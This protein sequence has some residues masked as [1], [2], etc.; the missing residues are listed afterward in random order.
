MQINTAQ[1]IDFNEFL[2]LPK[3]Q[4]FHIFEERENEVIH[5]RSYASALKDENVL[6]N[7]QL[8]TLRHKLFGRSSEKPANKG[9]KGGSSRGSS[10]SEK[11]KKK[12]QLPSERYPDAP[13][14]ETH[15]T[16]PELPICKCCGSTM[17]DSGMTEDSEFLTTIPARHF[18]V[19]QKRH[20][21]RCSCHGDI[22]TAPGPDRITPGGSYSDDMIIDVALN[23]YCNLVPI[24]RYT[25]IAGREG[26]KDLPSHS[27]IEATHQLANF[28]EPAYQKVRE[29]VT[30]ALVLHADET[31]HKMLEGD[32]TP[33]WF[34]WAFSTPFSSYFD[35]RDTRSGDVASELLKD[36]RCEYLSSDVFSG[37]GKAVR[38]TNKYRVEK[39]HPEIKHVFCNAHV[40]RKFKESAKEITE[41]IQ[42]FL[43]KY[44]A[45]YKLEKDSREAG[46]LLKRR[47]E[48]MAH[49]LE[50]K[51]YAES[52]LTSNSSKSAI[53]SACNYFLNNYDGFTRF[54]DD[55][56]LPIDNNHQ[57]RQLRN[58]VIGRKTWFGTHSRRGAQTA[59]ILFS[60][61]ESCKLNEVNPRHYFLALVE[62]IHSKKEP[63][64]PKSYRE[65]LSN[66]G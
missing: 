29:E 48:M 8:V 3:E 6:I 13:L 43:D 41:E 34:L 66:T 38:E 18:V 35:I 32:K 4:Q 23:K 16:F 50:M 26:F 62:G 37:Y 47:Q 12:I 9:A 24:D 20:K 46:G 14:I 19:R 39:E 36:S 28:V 53:V 56:R 25:K 2:L 59:A 64:T 10:G 65:L 55:I 58:P 11:R 30:A 33:N 21:Y 60:L 5:L 40:R 61:V 42:F 44:G 7:N 45:I 51:E 15:I 17:Q 63:F 54:V 1:K 22:K 49:F 52:L 31:P 57:E 27:L